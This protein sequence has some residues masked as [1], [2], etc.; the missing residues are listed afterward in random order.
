MANTLTQAGVAIR[1]RGTRGIGALF[2]PPPPGGGELP[3]EMPREMGAP[4]GRPVPRRA[5]AHPKSRPPAWN[6]FLT[7]FDLFGAPRRGA[8]GGF[9]RK[10]FN[11]RVR[12]AHFY[13]RGGF[14]VT[15]LRPYCKAW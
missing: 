2:T 4:K 12:G 13:P 9:P 8:P 1:P 11:G 15:F 5:P 3:R 14:R 10:I 6:F 7:L